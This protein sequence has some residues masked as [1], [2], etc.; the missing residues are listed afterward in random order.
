MEYPI[1]ESVWRR[2]WSDTKKAWKNW[3][4]Y[5]FNLLAGGLIGGFFEWYWGLA[6]VGFGVVCVWM[7]A[8]GS[9]PI[10]QRNEVRKEL[11]EIKNRSGDAGYVEAFIL[12]YI[13]LSKV[14][15][16]SPAFTD[17]HK[18]GFEN[19]SADVLRYLQASHRQ[20]EKLQWLR[21][22]CVDDI[23]RTSYQSVVNAYDAGYKILLELHGRLTD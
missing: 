20:Q 12:D 22:V 15:S 3:K 19:W 14:L 2:G 9:A 18:R 5:V 16:T 7:A 23:Y 6:V 4:F 10:R 21:E 11:T 13:E 8:T 17:H 1:D